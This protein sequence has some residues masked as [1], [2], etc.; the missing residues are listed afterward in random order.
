VVHAAVTAR[1]GRATVFL[2][3]SGAGKSTLAVERVRAGHVYLSDEIAAIRGDEVLAVPRPIKLHDDVA[4]AG[5]RPEGDDRFEPRGYEYVDLER[6]RRR[7]MLY[8][9]RPP[10]VASAG[11]RLALGDV[12]LLERGE[13]GPPI[14]RLLDGA[15]R[16]ARLALARLKAAE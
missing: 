12:F 11:E 4:I 7:A 8:L 2:G 9:P 10:L 15:E 1:G 16:R 13:D 14:Q 5:L 6:Q 3:D